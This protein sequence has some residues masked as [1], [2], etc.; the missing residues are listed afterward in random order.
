MSYTPPFVPESRKRDE[1]LQDRV[2]R[3]R[4]AREAAADRVARRYAEVKPEKRSWQADETVQ[5]WGHP[6]VL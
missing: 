2:T 3:A 5:T 6:R 1:S 4:R